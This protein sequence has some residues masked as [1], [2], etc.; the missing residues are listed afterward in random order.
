MRAAFSATYPDITP[1]PLVP[2]RLD[3]MSEGQSLVGLVDSGAL[4]TTL[5][6]RLADAMEIDLDPSTRETMRVG[7]STLEYYWSTVG[8]IVGQHKW[9]SDVR[10]AHGWNASHQLLGL[11]DLFVLFKVDVDAYAQSTEIHPRRNDPRI[12]RVRR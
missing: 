8:L 7:G 4:T 11:R 10:F 12:T 2:F 3:Q 6:A 1:R 5:D 9:D